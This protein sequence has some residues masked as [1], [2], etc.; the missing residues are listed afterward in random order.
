ML[1]SQNV[2]I[3][4]RMASQSGHNKKCIASCA[5]MLLTLVCLCICVHAGLLTRRPPRQ[6]SNVLLALLNITD[7]ATICCKVVTPTQRIFTYFHELFLL[8]IGEF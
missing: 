8:K 1:L 4:R 7:H 2:M 5:Y 3:S 6:G